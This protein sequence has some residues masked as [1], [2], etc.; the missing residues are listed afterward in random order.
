MVGITDSEMLSAET[1]LISSVNGSPVSSNLTTLRD[2]PEPDGL[3]DVGGT[4]EEPSFQV[5]AC[6]VTARL[7]KPNCSQDASGFEPVRHGAFNTVLHAGGSCAS[8]IGGFGF[9]GLTGGFG[10]ITG[11]LNQ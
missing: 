1:P 10:W 6:G 9:G 8:V 7:R 3:S 2:V 4:L 11:S 5:D